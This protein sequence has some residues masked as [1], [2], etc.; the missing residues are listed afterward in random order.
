MPLLYSRS[1]QD[2]N[3]RIYAI[4]EK[5]L[6]VYP[7][8]SGYVPAPA[9]GVAGSTTTTTTTASAS[10][11]SKSPLSSSMERSNSNSSTNSD[12]DNDKKFKLQNPSDIGL[13]T[14]LNHTFMVSVLSFTMI[15]IDIV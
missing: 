10:T 14:C 7:S 1:L 15:I 6:K 11:S 8:G 5:M 9:V 13:P 3:S 4:R 12:N 2:K